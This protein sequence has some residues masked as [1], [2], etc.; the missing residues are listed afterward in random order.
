MPPP[1]PS[2]LLQ[3]MSADSVVLIQAAIKRHPEDGRVLDSAFAALAGVV[4]SDDNRV[5]V[6]SPSLHSQLCSASAVAHPDLPS[7]TRSCS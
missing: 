6:W 3:Y 1:A 4:R 2:P 5:R 7:L